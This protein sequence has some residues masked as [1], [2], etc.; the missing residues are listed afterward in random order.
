MQTK[1]MKEG[2]IT[3]SYFINSHEPA[4]GV[5]GRIGEHWARA[6]RGK[7]RHYRAPGASH[8]SRAPPPG[9]LRLEPHLWAVASQP[10]LMMTWRLRV[11]RLCPVVEPTQRPTAR[12]QTPGS[13]QQGDKQPF[14]F[15]KEGEGGKGGKGK[16]KKKNRKGGRHTTCS[17]LYY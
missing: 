5:R 3:V 2:I 12:R 6:P 14:S 17:T 9:E 4:K 7:G 11:P 13:P 15:G 8:P 1:E 16:G 10:Q